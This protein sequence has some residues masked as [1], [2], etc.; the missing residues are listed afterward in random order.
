MA[1]YPYLTKEQL[2]FLLRTTSPHSFANNVKAMNKMLRLP[3]NTEPTLDQLV[4]PSGQSEDTVT[5]LQNFL[6]SLMGEVARG[7]HIVNT[8]QL[9]AVDTGEL[10]TEQQRDVLTALAKWLGDMSV[11]CR[12]EAMKFGIP[13]EEVQEVIQGSLTTQ[14]SNDGVPNYDGD[15]KFI[16]DYTNYIAAEAGIKTLMFGVVEPK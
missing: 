7:Q 13:I 16:P 5:H 8:L 12:S 6:A 11:S 9:L 14:L 3:I 4:T 1:H 2:A 10:T 15:G